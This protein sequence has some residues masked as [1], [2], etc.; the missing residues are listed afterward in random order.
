MTPR[1][2]LKSWFAAL[3]AFMVGLMLAS[4]AFAGQ[5]VDLRSDLQS[6][7]PSIILGDLFNDAGRSADIPVAAA[8]ASA[9][10]MVLDAGEVQ[11]IAHMHGLDW[12]NAHGFRRLVVQ[13]GAAPIAAE[14][15]STAR[16]TG[17]TTDA[18]T[19]ARN[20]GAGEIVRPQDVIWAK[21][22]TH[23]VPGDAP[24]DPQ[25]MIGQSARRALREGAAASGRDLMAQ[26]LIKKDEIISVTYDVGGVTLTLQGKALGDASAGDTVQVLNTQSKKTIEAVATGPG[27]AVAGPEAES[28]KSRRFASLR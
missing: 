13:M 17:K 5:E 12:A 6:A 7:G 9:R 22:Q 18:L 14:P 23:M 11:R 4:A 26:Q 24:S 21:V 25:Q 27:E 10:S 8:P 20:I 15:A 19:Y 2:S 3:T 16:G 28:L 1:F